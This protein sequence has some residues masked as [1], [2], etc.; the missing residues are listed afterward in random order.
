MCQLAGY[1]DV[2]LSVFDTE[3]VLALF[4][5]QLPTWEYR[6]M[7]EPSAVLIVELASNQWEHKLSVFP[8]RF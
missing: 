5:K 2:C 3:R 1:A 8:D 7:P 4:L 6:L